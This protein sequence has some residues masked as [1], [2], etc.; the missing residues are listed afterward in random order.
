MGTIISSII[1]RSN[2]RI[3]QDELENESL[4]NLWNKFISSHNL[5]SQNCS[6]ASSSDE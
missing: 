1:R 4:R 3:Y 2:Q 5:T 6:E